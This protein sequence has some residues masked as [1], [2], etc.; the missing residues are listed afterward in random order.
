MI[1]SILKD[2]LGNLTRINELSK[3]AFDELN[4]FLQRK[5]CNISN[6][7]NFIN[8]FS[9]SILPLSEEFSTFKNLSSKLL[10]EKSKCSN[11]KIINNTRDINDVTIQDQTVNQKEIEEVQN[12]LIENMVTENVNVCEKEAS[13]IGKIEKPI[14]KLVDFDKL[15][16]PRN[17]RLMNKNQNENNSVIILSSSEDE[18]PLCNKNNETCENTYK[19]SSEDLVPTGNSTSLTKGSS[20]ISDKFQISINLYNHKD[21]K[22]HEAYV[23]LL[24]VPCE[25]MKEFY[26]Q[27]MKN[28][29]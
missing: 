9:L 11:Q 10:E 2:L 19:S 16:D 26:S 21:V 8:D 1:D 22:L 25:E 6:N 23:K 3:N 7:S 18:E 24:R 4:E 12:E 20:T 27:R 14:L 29:K 17:L 15:V 5:D 28:N 13:K